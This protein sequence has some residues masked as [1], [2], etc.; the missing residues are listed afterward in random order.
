MLANFSSSLTSISL[1]HVFSNQ[2]DCICHFVQIMISTNLIG[3]FYTFFQN[4]AY[5]LLGYLITY[6]FRFFRIILGL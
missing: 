4:V 1:I 3:S 2:E 5:F 6:I